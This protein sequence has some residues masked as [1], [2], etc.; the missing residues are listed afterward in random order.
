MTPI[1]R[2]N[3]IQAGLF[4]S[5]WSHVSID[6]AKTLKEAV[7]PTSTPSSSN[8]SQLKSNH[9]NQN[10]KE[11]LNREFISLFT[12]ITQKR[13]TEAIELIKDIFSDVSSPLGID[14]KLEIYTAAISQ[15]K[16]YKSANQNTEKKDAINALFDRFVAEST[17]HVLKNLKP[18]EKDHILKQLTTED[19]KHLDEQFKLIEA[20]LK[21]GKAILFPSDNSE[22]EFKLTTN[23]GTGLALIHAAEQSRMLQHLAL[24]LDFDNKVRELQKHHPK[25]IRLDLITENV[26][27]TTTTVVWGA[28]AYNCHNPEK[29]GEGHAKTVEQLVLK[30][31][32]KT[33]SDFLVGINTMGGSVSPPSS[34]AA[35][36][37]PSGPS[38]D[39]VSNA[40]SGPSPDEHVPSKNND[41]LILDIFNKS[42][43]QEI[44]KAAD[45][46]LTKAKAQK[47]LTNPTDSD[48]ALKELLQQIIDAHTI[49]LKLQESGQFKTLD[50]GKKNEMVIHQYVL[51]KDAK[52]SISSNLTVDEYINSKLP[53]VQSVETILRLRNL[54]NTCFI[55]AALQ[56]L[57][58]M[59]GF[60][61]SVELKKDTLEIPF[62]L[63]PKPGTGKPNIDLKT[64]KYSLLKILNGDN[65]EQH[66]ETLID[67]ISRFPSLT[68]GKQDAS[69][70][71]IGVLCDIFGYNSGN[72]AMLN[73]SDTTTPQTLAS[74]E[75]T[76][77]TSLD[78]FDKHFIVTVQSDLNSA[79]GNFFGVP[80]SSDQITFNI[81]GKSVKCIGSTLHIGEGPYSGHYVYAEHKS[82]TK[83]T[84]Y[85]DSKIYEADII[86]NPKTNQLTLARL[87]SNSGYEYIYPHVRPETL[88]C[89]KIDQT[90]L[91]P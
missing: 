87:N 11:E 43:P 61:K 49:E 30:H 19:G 75:I 3:H 34:T 57:K 18:E 4:S 64:L 17:Q 22:Q 10:F 44:I 42:T 73:V 70:Y 8:Y 47:V 65:D 79:N 68:K 21:N 33:P 86:N 67:Q 82:G 80:Q 72:S 50:Q 66:L 84:I 28:N 77:S 60:K 45:E 1:E 25:N 32:K 13:T 83:F 54:G 35:P 27:V 88:V 39:V 23:M 15:F 9:L 58:Q 31:P 46:A 40:T 36:K 90:Y 81:N 69:G 29:G 5:E 71:V 85:D 7:S 41:D 55:N 53:N 59:E 76:I 12:Y 20:S 62:T 51:Y 48:H 16:N 52:K 89:E 63:Q 56:A 74:N 37:S 14:D 2:S 26:D 78:S 6:S 24:L 91:T 38:S